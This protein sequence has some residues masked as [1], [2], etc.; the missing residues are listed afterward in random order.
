VLAGGVGELFIDVEIP[1]GADGERSFR[2]D[3]DGAGNTILG[4]TVFGCGFVGFDDF[5]G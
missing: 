5:R 2:S 1:R 4:V 3:G